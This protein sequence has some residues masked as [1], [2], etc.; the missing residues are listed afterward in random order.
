MITPAA[1]DRT[2]R[3]RTISKTGTFVPITFTSAAEKLKIIL[4]ENMHASPQSQK[5]LQRRAEEEEWAHAMYGEWWSTIH[6][7]L[8]T[9]TQ[10]R[11]IRTGEHLMIRRTLERSASIPADSLAGSHG[12]WLPGATRQGFP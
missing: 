3:A 7:W 2:D 9:P 6:Q 11:T 1:M 5:V 8:I 12:G 4:A 10:T